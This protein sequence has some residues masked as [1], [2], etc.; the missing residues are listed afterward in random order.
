MGQPAMNHFEQLNSYNVALYMRLSRDDGDSGESESIT[1]QRK[2]LM[3]YV[4]EQ[5]FIIAGEYVDDGWSGTSFHR[6]GFQKMLHDIPIK[7]INCVITKDLSRLGRDHIMTG[8]YI[9]NYFPENGIRYIAIND[10]VDTDQG[11]NDITPFMNVFNEFHAKTTSKKIRNVFEA[12]FKEGECH[13]QIPPMGYIKDPEK[14]NHLIPDP[15]TRWI[16]EKIFELADGGM[17]PWAIRMWLYNNKVITPGY[18][19]YLKW[20]SYAK[21]YEDAPE[22]RKYEWGIANVKNILKNTLYTGTITHYKKR[23]ISYK[24]RKA[25]P[26]PVHKQLVIENSH[27]GI[28]SKEQFDRVQ[29]MIAVRRRKNSTQGEPHIFAGITVCADCGGY[30][31]YGANNKNKDKPFR[32][33][34]CGRKSDIGT[35]AC[36]AHYT[37]YDILCEAVLSSIQELF[38]QVSI[39]KEYVIRKLSESEKKS[40]ENN[41]D[42][43]MLEKSS[44]IKR[45]EE[46][47]KILSKLYEDWASRCISEIMFSSMSDKFRKEHTEII[48]KIED[49]LKMETSEDD[50]ENNVEM[51]TSIVEGLSYPTELTRELVNALIERIEIHEPEGKKHQKNKPQRIEIF[52]RFVLPENRDVIFK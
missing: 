25:K 42:A 16:I 23:T 35:R 6:P 20:G 14:K 48:K 19:A 34:C 13:Y 11:D 46:I 9:E 17:G 40:K 2:I 43:I 37:N 28:V 4:K 26:Q 24:N 32:Y 10:K 15:E 50:D 12:K 51:L 36:T 33:L 3:S 52:W 45:K 49:L 7:K 29:R 31:R 21:T 18:R 41:M 5:G 8:Y 39:D 22:S 47:E 44:L 30:L 38:R 27:E 1:N